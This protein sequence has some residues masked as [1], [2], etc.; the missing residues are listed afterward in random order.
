MAI[1]RENDG[2]AGADSGTRYTLSLGDVFQGALDPANDKDWI[3]VE[4]TAGTIY[5]ITLT[6]VESAQLQLLDSEGNHV[7]SG[8]SFPSGSKLIFSPAASGTY[9][10]NAGSNDN[11]Y[12]GDYEI[13]LVENTI[14]TGTY[15]EFADYLTD[16]YWKWQGGSGFAFDVEPGGVLTA[17]IT[18]LTEEGQQL[19]RWAL[20]AWTNVTGIKFESVDDNNANITFYNDEGRGFGGPTSTVSDG[21]IV[22]SHVN[23][24]E[25]YHIESG[26]TLGS[27]SFYV[28]VHEIGHALGL[29]HP[30]PYPKDFDNPSAAYGVENIFLNDS[31]Q[32]SL[33]SYFSQTDNTYI[34]ASYAIPVTPMIAD[35]IAIQNLYGVPTDINAGDTVYGYHSNVDGYLGEVFKLWTGELNPFIN[36]GL[37]DYTSAPTIKPTLT[38]LDGDGDPDLVVGNDSGSLYYFENTGTSANPSFTE[39]TGTDNPLDSVT[40]GSYSTPSFTDLDGD[41]DLDFIVGNGDGDIAYF[42]NTGTV[43]AP[44]F[45]QRT[46]A[47]N[48]F[49]TITKGSWSTVALADLDGDGD[50]DLAVGNNDGDVHYYENTGTSANPDFVLRTG[51]TS[52]LNNINAGS[53]STPVFVDF[54]DDN[55]PDLVVG[56]GNENIY[57]FE[58]TG[59]TTA[60]SFIQRTDSDNPFQGTNA[61]GFSAPE[62]VDLNGDGNLDLIIGNQVGEIHY[63]KN[64]GTDASPE[65]SP[66]SLTA[67]TTLTLYDNG[68]NDTLDLRTDTRDQRVYLR[69]EGISDV[70]GLTGNLII[71]RDTVIENF[72][73]GSGDDLVAGNA[74]ANYLNGRDGDDRLWGS[75][76]DDIL[77]GGAGADQLDGDAG[78]DWVSYRGS[79]AAVTVNLGLGTVMGGHAEGDVLIEIENVIGSDYED[80]LVGN[81]GANRLEGGA[82]ADLL[83]GGAG[84]DWVSYQWSDAGVVV[85]LTEGTAEGGHAQGDVITNI[86]NVTGSDYGDV[87][88]GDEGAN[89]LEGGEGDDE[90]YGGAGADMLNGG[91]GD[92]H[93]Y[94]TSSSV[95]VL[96]RLH[97]ANAVKYGEAEGDTLIDVEHLVGSNHNDVLAGDG[98]DNLLDGGDGD[99]VLYGGPA[100]GDDM[101]YGGNGDDRIFGGKGNDIL[102]GGEGNDYLKGGPGEDTLIA[103]GDDMDVLYGGTEKDTFQFFPSN[104]GG[105]SIRDFSDGEDVIDLTE[106]TGI[107]SMDDLDIVSHGDNVRIELSG[108][109][110]LTTIIL[111]D[112]DIH[113][114]DNSDFLF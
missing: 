44:S 9:Y 45:T 58:N 19:A 84:I 114:L 108:S 82:G 86:E 5:D 18:A 23:V 93:A 2:D 26:T 89:R 79:D 102:T 110:Y 37:V 98:E 41:G 94:Y 56:S 10:I 29:G 81:D 103:D 30:G 36:I 77:E 53:Y 32:V 62:F 55:D 78:L 4:L 24:P 70:Y 7:V 99:D 27:W 107:S 28:Y 52:P 90:L 39:H 97:N 113:N 46:G 14:P 88:W 65:F 34:N 20:E 109:D 13:T 104:L 49:D 66:T 43:T 48:P 35:I 21:V 83:D 87:L 91:P 96:V 6:G 105:G 50:L 54:D 1:I 15:D 3:R 111:S 101:M 71:A 76:G 33:M 42:E 106:F 16:G 95:G 59:T 31:F 75:G 67:P 72:I 61:G 22:S 73:A 68:G 80:V 40:V 8:G 25:Y 38:D 92:D 85:D 57:Y 112:F 74:V 47:A 64:T 100:G 60:P 51:E 11:D 69:P 63:F 12:S 17:D